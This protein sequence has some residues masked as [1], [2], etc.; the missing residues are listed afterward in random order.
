MSQ[1]VFERATSELPFRQTPWPLSVTD[2][3]Y[4]KKLLFVHTIKVT[5]NINTYITWAIEHYLLTLKQLIIFYWQGMSRLRQSGI[6]R[7]LQRTH[8]TTV[9]VFFY[10]YNIKFHHFFKFL[11][12]K[13]SFILN[14]S[15]QA[16]PLNYVLI[17]L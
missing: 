1:L 15:Q 9:A 2:R 7:T 8:H 4:C 17:N 16:K 5:Q 11:Y 6:Y 13:K 12:T 3:M 10:I 14:C